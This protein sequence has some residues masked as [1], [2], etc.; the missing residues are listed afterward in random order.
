[1]QTKS[2]RANIS[3]AIL[4]VS[5]TDVGISECRLKLPNKCFLG[6]CCPYTSHVSTRCEHKGTYQSTFADN[7]IQGSLCCFLDL[8]KNNE[9]KNNRKV[10]VSIVCIVV[11]IMVMVIIM[12][13]ILSRQRIRFQGCRAAFRPQS[14]RQ[15][16]TSPCP[17]DKE[18]SQLFP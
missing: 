2:A 15:R 4:R 1:M 10:T 11:V 3:D 9:G 16:C 8:V 5:S 12:S 6:S 18:R 13:R 14:S 7:T 17:P